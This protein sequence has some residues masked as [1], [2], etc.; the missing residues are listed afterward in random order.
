MENFKD[1]L[2]S[3]LARNDW[4]N[5]EF[6]NLVGAKQASVSQWI[7]GKFVPQPQTLIKIAEVTHANPYELF[8][9]V[10]GLPM[11]G[12]DDTPEQIERIMRKAEALPENVQ[13]QLE[14][15]IDFLLSRGRKENA[16]SDQTK[17]SAAHRK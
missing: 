1:W 8:N 10:Y 4:T 2:R 14:A 3:Q 12:D 9:M 17:T 6:G 15:Y 13:E 7:N 5:E 16:E 11:P